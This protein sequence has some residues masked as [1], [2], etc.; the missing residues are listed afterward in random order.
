MAFNS[1]KLLNFKASW[2]GSILISKHIP[3]I[4]GTEKA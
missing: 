1:S 4:N 3:S 2:T